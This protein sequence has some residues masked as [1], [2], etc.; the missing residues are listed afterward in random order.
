MRQEFSTMRRWTAFSQMVLARLK[1][2]YREPE[3]IFWVYGFPV[4]LAVGL[5]IA[6]WNRPPESARVDVVQGS[7][8]INV[9]ELAEA[10]KAGGLAV[11]VH[12][13]GEC[14]HRYITGKTALFVN[15]D[16]KDLA[17][18]ID[19]TRS[20]SLAARYQVE[21]IVR[22]WKTPDAVTTEDRPETEPGNRYID[23]LMPGLMG[24][25]LMGGGMWGVGFVLV[26][27]RVRKLLKRL[28]ATP[29]RR[30]DLLL[31]ILASRM[32]M[33]LPEMLSLF[34]VAYFVF[35]VPMRGN[36]VT[37][38]L[39]LL[40]G[41]FTFSGMGLLAASRTEKTETL[42]GLINLAMLPMWL[43]SGVFFSSK[44][45][46]DAAQP[47]IQALP[48]TQLNDGLRE[49]ILEGKSLP[50]VAWRLAILAGYAIVT[51]AVGLRLFRWK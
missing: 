50:D 27:L 5:A 43:L 23:F 42:V 45:F 41:A 15:W 12:Y 13:E 11:E 7:P 47:F 3:A 37:L 48:L 28:L 34:I 33:L 10:L 49:V 8:G 6:F 9:Q 4:I 22:K 35:G 32:I 36:P 26:E 40:I 44:K 14:R 18:G 20:E 21:A 25:N 30:G 29:M 17:F 38:V 51:F 1:E 24:M 31:A 39:L 19:P 2:F 46:P 16:G